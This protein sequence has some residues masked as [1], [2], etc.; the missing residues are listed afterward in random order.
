ML[1]AQQAKEILFEISYF[2]NK[3][4]EIN[5]IISDLQTNLKDDLP[6]TTLKNNEKKQ[7]LLTQRDE[8]S[9]KFENLSLILPDT[10]NRD[11][12]K[13]MTNLEKA[14]TDITHLIKDPQPNGKCESLTRLLE[15]TKIGLGALVEAHIAAR[16][17]IASP[18]QLITIEE[19]LKLES[20]II[21]FERNSLQLYRRLWH[22]FGGF[23]VAFC[24]WYSGITKDYALIIL[25]F[26]TIAT[27]AIDSLRLV[28]KSLNERVLRD[29]RLII[30]EDEKNSLSAMTYYLVGSWLSIFLFPPFIATLAIFFLAFADP[31]ASIVG[32]K[33]GRKKWK[34]GKTYE[35]SLAAFFTC[36]FLSFIFLLGFFG[37]SLLKTFLFSTT[38]ALAGTFA[39]TFPLKIDDNLAIP[40]VS[41]TIMWF[42]FLFI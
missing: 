22:M 16:S 36:F 12:N 14:K 24:Y 2:L 41:G 15:E 25:G 6:L 35:G 42:F 39:E 19:K 28:F 1:K 11:I 33:Y 8:L 13:L 37:D 18:K 7:L 27:V 17:D 34:W 4:N 20:G 5:R 9:D 29:F 38:F 30:R 10:F 40:I 31:I 23:S 32:I 3:K 21:I 26:I